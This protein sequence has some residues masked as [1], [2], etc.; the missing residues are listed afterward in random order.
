MIGTQYIANDLDARMPNRI[1]FLSAQDHISSAKNLIGFGS[2]SVRP[3]REQFSI[4]A[5]R[6]PRACPAQHRSEFVWRP[7]WNGRLPAIDVLGSILAARR[8]ACE[9]RIRIP[10]WTGG[11]S[12]AGTCCESTRCWRWGQPYTAWGLPQLHGEELAAAIHHCKTVCQKAGSK[13]NQFC[14]TFL[15]S[16]DHG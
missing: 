4:L 2:T 3:S 7:S 5:D 8:G 15:F 13:I 16:I 10:A 12:H 11:L 6:P 14:E 9:P 1:Y